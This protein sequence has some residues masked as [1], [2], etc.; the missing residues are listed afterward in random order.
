MDLTQLVKNVASNYGRMVVAILSTLFLTPFLL[1]KLGTEA[2][3]LWG[4]SQAIGG[5][6][7][8]MD[9]GITSAA[10]R[11][12]AHYRALKDW[13]NLN[14]VVGS[15]FLSYSYMAL[16]CLVLGV[17]LAAFSPALFSKSSLHLQL[18]YLII[19]VAAV[20]SIGFLTVM[21]LQCVIA[22][23]R[24]DLL[25]NWMLLFQI[26]STIATVICVN[27]G[28]GVLALASI[29]LANTVLNGVFGYILMGKL[30]PE[31]RLFPCWDKVQGRLILSFA[32][33]AFLITVAVRLINFSDTLVVGSFI[34]VGAVASYVVI[35]KVIELMRSL[36][37]TG[38]SIMG[39]FVSEQAALGRLEPLR[40]MWVYG[41]KW[42][43][44]ITLP[45]GVA[46]LFISHELISSWVGPGYGEAEVA[47]RWLAGC[48][49]CD[50]TQ[51][52]AYQVLMNSG[53]HKPLAISMSI[54]GIANLILSI[55][56]AQKIGL[57]GVAVGTFIPCMIRSVV[58]YPL[59]MRRIT[60]LGLSTYVREAIYPA[61]LTAAPSSALIITYKLAGWHSGR[62]SLLLLILACALILL[63][64]L[65]LF[66]LSAEERSRL[67]QWLKGSPFYAR[68]R[69]KGSSII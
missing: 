8:L 14:K 10:V 5:Y 13:E 16:A 55:V 46:C 67:P 58:F 33:W 47:L 2:Y 68:W 22:A 4:V 28:H 38:V 50:L 20:G 1:H 23:Q 59:Y 21:P 66:G 52:A 12:V 19:A 65:G 34:S 48:A 31:V 51:S 60:G 45:M 3:G 54:E 7:S 9:L 26:V 41:S 49:V 56:L 25:N 27:M 17:I 44:A 43:L 57:V 62:I 32:S 15:S 35:L 6:F 69:L 30:L 40:S 63:V 36:V 18:Q 64:S 61:L 37:G 11:Y 42:A 29:Q 39:T 53:R 24:Q